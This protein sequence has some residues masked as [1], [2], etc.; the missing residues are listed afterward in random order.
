MLQNDPKDLLVGNSGNTKH[1]EE[2]GIPT[3]VDEEL[4]MKEKEA[5]S[6]VGEDGT[7]FHTLG[8]ND[9]LPTEL[10]SYCVNCEK[11]GITK[12][13]F[14]KIPHFREIIISSFE[15]PHCGYRNQEVQFGGAY[16]D[17]GIEITL[18]VEKKEDLDRQI[19]K[20]DFAT[21]RIPEIDFE[22]PEQ[23]QK[24]VLTTVEGILNRTIDALLDGQPSRRVTDPE[25]AAKIDEFIEKLRKLLSLETKF[26]VIIDDY[27]GNSNIEKLTTPND[28]QIHSKNYQR[29]IEQIEKLGLSIG[30]DKINEDPETLKKKEQKRL[31]ASVISNEKEA[32]KLQEKLSAPEEVFTFPASCTGC[33]I[34]GF[35][36]MM[37]LQIPYFKEII[38]MAFKCDTCGFKSTEVRAGG[39]ISDK[40]TKLSLSVLNADDLSR[41]VLKSETSSVEIPEIQLLVTV[42]SLGGRFTTVEGL[43][44]TIVEKL[45]ETNE[46][47]IGDSAQSKEK[48]EE[49]MSNFKKMQEG[50]FGPWTL[51]IDDPVSN[52]YIQNLCAPDPDPQ[53]KV[54]HYDRSF[55]QNE[56]LGLNDLKTENYE[57]ELHSHQQCHDCNCEHEELS[58][59]LEEKQTDSLEDVQ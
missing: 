42:G 28:P 35:V 52:S 27:S 7:I 8:L 44:E 30:A 6:Y 24:G 1:V 43:L 26:T 22:I 39:A 14:T 54:E 53:L 59:K 56:E 18:N 10:E 11:N 31:F 55:E 25:I 48:F 45:K 5:K 23:T 20:S 12:F 33:G 37:P 38:L 15:C 41:D 19:V 50:T 16:Q 3:L 32:E 47:A 51:I 4:L 49:F 46:F 2:E 40:A 13:L 17:M 58:T 36:K 21:L 57:D 29:T 9:Q 34:E